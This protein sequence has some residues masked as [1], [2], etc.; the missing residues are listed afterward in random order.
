MYKRVMSIFIIFFISLTSF[1]EVKSE[2]K[3]KVTLYTFLIPRYVESKE[4]GEFIVLAKKLAE[5]AGFDLT[6]EVYPAKR[7]L[8][9][10]SEGSADGYFP[11]LDTLN[12]FSVY[13]TS[14]FYIKE[15]FVFQMKGKNYLTHKSPKA[16][17][18][19]GYPYTKSVLENKK[20][21]VIYAKSDEK[22]LELLSIDRAQVFVGEEYTAIA[23]L[24]S[25]KIIDSVAYDRFRPIST[26]NVYFA[27]SE[28]KRGKILSQKFDQA[29]KKLVMNGFYDSLFPEK[30]R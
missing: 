14:D 15:D 10:F 9:K 19:S 1:A 12:P 26:Q 22:C 8:Q 25:L 2:A 5:L 30:Q 6:I 4:K 11:A 20:W 24:K 21:E 29:L 23:A 17:L 28:N 7:A 27:F 13:K 18:T 16:C 3:E